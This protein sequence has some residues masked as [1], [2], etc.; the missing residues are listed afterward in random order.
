MKTN[1]DALAPPGSGNDR[2]VATTVCEVAETDLFIENLEDVI[3]PKLA[4]NHNETMV[5]DSQ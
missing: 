3:A 5:S 1:H 4:A 2:S